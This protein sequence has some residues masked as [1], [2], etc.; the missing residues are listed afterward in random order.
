MST[1]STGQRPKSRL[2][3]EASEALGKLEQDESFLRNLFRDL[4]YVARSHIERWKWPGGRKPLPGDIAADA[5][6]AIWHGKRTWN[7]SERSL[8][9]ECRRIIPSLVWNAL[10]KKAQQ[11]EGALENGANCA[12]DAGGAI[13]PSH[14]PLT[15][16]EFWNDTVQAQSP[17]GALASAGLSALEE[18]GALPI[19]NVG[20][21]QQL[22][23]LRASLPTEQ[24][25]ENEL[26][27]RVVDEI[28]FSYP[29][30]EPA[31]SGNRP[32]KPG[33]ANQEL[34]VKLGVSESEVVNAKKRL[35]HVLAARLWERFLTKLPDDGR[36]W[37]ALADTAERPRLSD[38][39]KQGFAEKHSLT[40]GQVV[41]LGMELVELFRDWFVRMFRDETARN[42]ASAL[43]ERAETIE[44]NILAS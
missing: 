31:N 17:S 22:A 8:R 11:V 28:A 20:V 10:T 39:W 43:Q 13:A 18:W 2:T 29:E 3:K 35:R 24:T 25:A 14:D 26:L 34:A 12:E 15:E 27:R 37:L 6:Y 1:D 41:E 33:W 4:F 36:P 38:D 23:E 44:Q 30:R 21:V 40:V 7:P 32:R 16:L 19:W 5:V 42:R 9:D